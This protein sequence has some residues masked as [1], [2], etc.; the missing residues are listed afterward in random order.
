M[1]EAERRDEIGGDRAP[2]PVASRSRALTRPG[3]VQGG[4]ILNFGAVGGG[5]RRLRRASQLL[6]R[7]SSVRR[8]G[9]SLRRAHGGERGA[10]LRPAGRPLFLFS[11]AARARGPRV[12]EEAHVVR[13]HEPVDAAGRAQQ[14][15]HVA[16]RAERPGAAR[17]WRWRADKRQE[18]VALL[19]RRRRG[20]HREHQ[21]AAVAILVDCTHQPERGHGEGLRGAL[22]LLVAALSTKGQQAHWSEHEPAVPEDV[23]MRRALAAPALEQHGL[24]VEHR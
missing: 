11:P 19:G 8:S 21:S 2:S 23:Q 14:R 15:W 6:C 16:K 10:V 9:L 7:R 4:E 5:L 3:R 17:T 12:A 20:A 1:K 24:A 13:G 18:D 22:A